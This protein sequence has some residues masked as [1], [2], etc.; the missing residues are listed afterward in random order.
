MTEVTPMS[1]MGYNRIRGNKLQYEQA[2]LD[3]LIA[4]GWFV[5]YR[6]KNNFTYYV[7]VFPDDGRVTAT[8]LEDALKWEYEL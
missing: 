1:A 3:E 6:K 4:A 2:M 5:R 7:K 8:S